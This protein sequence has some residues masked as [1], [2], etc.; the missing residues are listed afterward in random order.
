M[1]NT[2]NIII[3]TM[4]FY[5]LR[6]KKPSD[7]NNIGSIGEDSDYFK[8]YRARGQVASKLGRAFGKTGIYFIKENGRLIY[9]GYSGSN[10]YKTILRHFQTWNDAYQSGR[11]SYKEHLDQKDYTVR[12]EYMPSEAAKLAECQ[13]INEYK[14]RDNKRRNFWNNAA[15]RGSYDSTRAYVVDPKNGLRIFEDSSQEEEYSDDDFSD[16]SW[17]RIAEEEYDFED[18]IPF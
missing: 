14:P 8:P 3:V 12:I 5:L 6:G 13:L 9:I 18:D 15:C 11:I 1:L 2:K 4:A 16:P 17:N 7:D 10:L